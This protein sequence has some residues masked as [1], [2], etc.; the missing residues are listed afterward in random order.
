MSWAHIAGWGTWAGLIALGLNLG[1]RV[2]VV[3][4]ALRTRAARAGEPVQLK[5]RGLTVVVGRVTRPDPDD[6]RPAYRLDLG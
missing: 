1:F 4:A 6:R 5:V 3:R 2:I